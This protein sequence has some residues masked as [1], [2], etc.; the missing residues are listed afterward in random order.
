[1]NKIDTPIPNSPN[2]RDGDPRTA[3]LYKFPGDEIP[4]IGFANWFDHADDPDHPI[5]NVFWT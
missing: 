4:I 3:D 1:M 2:G 5:A